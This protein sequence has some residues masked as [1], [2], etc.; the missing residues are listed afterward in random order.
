M[1]L[2][3]TYSETS[4][5]KSSPQHHIVKQTV[6]LHVE[7]TLPFTG[8]SQTRAAFSSFQNYRAT[9]I[10]PKIYVYR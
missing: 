6:L 8:L 10:F 5:G 2:W 9:E 3:R 7:E 4:R 1:M